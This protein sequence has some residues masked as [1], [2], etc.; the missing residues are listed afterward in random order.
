MINET[1]GALL[2]VLI[3]TLIPFLVYF[4]KKKSAKGFLEYIGLKKSTQKANYLAVLACLVIAAP[5]FILTLASPDFKEIMVDP[6]SITGK[7][8]QMGLGFN[9]LIILLLIAVFKTSFAEEVLFRGF[10]GKRLINLLG[11]QKGNLLQALIFGII[12]TALFAVITANILFLTLIFILPSIGAYIS[13]YLNEKL[14]NGSIIPGWISHAL[15]NIL[16]YSFIGFF[17]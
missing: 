16:A 10:I 6:T 7:F 13:G 14:A 15:A 4:I 3:F 1:I 11:F 2:Q 8:R 12:H 5:I 17:M 9:S